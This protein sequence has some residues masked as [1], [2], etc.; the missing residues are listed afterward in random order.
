MCILN[1]IVNA[2]AGVTQMVG[3]LCYLRIQSQEIKC[4]VS[5]V[6]LLSLWSQGGWH[7]KGFSQP[8]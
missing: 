3:Q 4:K 2:Y 8:T 6:Q 1:N 7:V 5:E